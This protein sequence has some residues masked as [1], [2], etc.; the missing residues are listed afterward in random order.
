MGTEVIPVRQLVPK[1]EFGFDTKGALKV[2]KGL[3]L[4]MPA[5]AA[6]I[7]LVKLGYLPE[8]WQ[9]PEVITVVTAIV[10]NI[11][12]F[13]RKFLVHYE[14]ASPKISVLDQMDGWAG[15][16]FGDVLEIKGY[17]H[18][19]IGEF[20]KELGV[21]PNQPATEPKQ[22]RALARILEE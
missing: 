8:T 3:G 14:Q 19:H 17:M 20:A 5:P 21:D 12:N 1:V 22:L 6:I 7:A 15:L 16:T 10:P 4:S 18:S 9:E 11:L 2:G 13:F